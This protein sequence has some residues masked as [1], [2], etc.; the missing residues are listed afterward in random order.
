MRRTSSKSTCCACGT[1]RTDPR[2]AAASHRAFGPP[3]STGRRVAPGAPDRA[4]LADRPRALSVRRQPVRNR[5]R[6][7]FV[8]RASRRRITMTGCTAPSRSSSSAAVRRRIT[9]TVTSL[10]P[11]R[12]RRWA[13]RSRRRCRGSYVRTSSSATQITSSPSDRTLGEVWMRYT[14]AA[15][16]R[17]QVVRRRRICRQVTYQKSPANGEDHMVVI[18]L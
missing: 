7:G 18:M 1:G 11:C 2:R 4:L 5:F 13:P 15:S 8:T 16:F 12:R 14:V 3:Y 9:V 6:T 10:S 17:A